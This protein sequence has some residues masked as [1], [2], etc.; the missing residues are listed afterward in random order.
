MPLG[1]TR[2]N[3]VYLWYNYIVSGCGAVG[4]AQCSGR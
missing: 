4:S 1:C 3:R 2:Y